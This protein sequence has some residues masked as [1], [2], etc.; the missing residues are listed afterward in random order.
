MSQIIAPDLVLSYWI[1]LWF[2]LYYWKFTQ[3]NPKFLL[4]LGFIENVIMLLLMFLYN[5]DIFKITVFILVN[6]FIKVLPLY[7]IWNTVI[8]WTDVYASVG[9]IVVYCVWVYLRLGATIY[10]VQR[11]IAKALLSNEFQTP[12]MSLVYSIRNYWMSPTK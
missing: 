7:F 12:I 5:N 11:N 6:F 9:L 1:F 8:T 3:Y 4:L 2:V 10:E